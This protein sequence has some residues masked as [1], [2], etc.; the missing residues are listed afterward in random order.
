MGSIYKITNNINGKIYI[1]QTSNQVKNR[2]KQHINSSINEGSR[3]YNTYL[4]IAM[5]KYGIDA[6]L[7]EEIEVCDN[8]QLDDREVFW[9]DYYNSFNNQ[10]GYNLTL[11]GGGSQVYKDEY[12][13]GMWNEGRTI[14]EIHD[15]SG[16]DRGWIS[17]RLKACGITDD[18]ISRRR[19]Q[20]TG[21]K[22]CKPV[23]QYALNGEYIKSFKSINE[24]R[25]ITG[26][27][28]IEKCCANK[29]KQAGGFQWSYQKLDKMPLY[30]C[31]KS[32]SVPKEVIQIEEDTQEIIA[33]Y[34]S[35]SDASRITGI[36]IS[37]IAKVCKGEQYT[38]GGYIWRVNNN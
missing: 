5:R 29:Q 17:V 33:E 6:F 25:R 31:I 10:C 21:E 7:V 2:W 37:G 34:K 3:D 18:E 9:I 15:E 28:H 20:S 36:D 1:G 27:G 23:Y 22:Q 13:L 24:A 30:E 11:G 14:S 38:A 32:K 19:Y 16:I 4:H 35:M 26:I 12:I 8:T